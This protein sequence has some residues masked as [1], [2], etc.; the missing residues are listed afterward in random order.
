MTLTSEKVDG[1]DVYMYTCPADYNMLIVNNGQGDQTENLVINTLKPY[2]YNNEWFESIEEIN[3][4]VTSLESVVL[5]NKANK[6]V[7]NGLFYIVREGVIYNA[8]GAVVR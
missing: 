6:V 1:K 5:N 4:T 2:F 8:Q 3:N 7:M